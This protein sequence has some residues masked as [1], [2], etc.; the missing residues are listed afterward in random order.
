L[1]RDDGYEPDQ[2]RANVQSFIDDGNIL[3]LVGCVGTPTARV[4]V[5]MAVEARLPFIGAFSGAKFLRE[6]PPARYVINYRASYEQETAAMVHYFLTIQQIEPSRI[7]VFSQADSYGDAGMDGVV[8]ALRRAGYR[9]TDDVL[10]VRYQRNSLDVS[11]AVEGIWDHRRRIDA[12]VMVGTYR[13]CARFIHALK[14]RGADFTFA[15]VSFVG[16]RSLAEE[17][18]ELEAGSAEGVL[19]TQVVPHPESQA[20][21]VMQYRETLARFQG[22]ERPGFVSLEGYIVAMMLKRALESAAS[23]EGEALIDAF[24]GIRGLD[25]GIGPVLNFGPSDHQGSNKVW[26]TRIKADGSFE[27]IRLD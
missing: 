7:A 6:V 14:S 21:G 9:D 3:G 25:L 16:S 10:H 18:N 20:T 12:V 24:E 23:I 4:T 11:E 17:L 8:A 26:G 2:A 27:V 22:Q 1:A 5:P 13:P 19:V 15:N